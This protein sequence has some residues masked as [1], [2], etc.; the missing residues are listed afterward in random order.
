MAATLTKPTTPAEL[1]A[2][3]TLSI[4]DDYD[5]AQL[6]ELLAEPDV[7]SVLLI[8]PRCEA[9]HVLAGV[10]P[11]PLCV[12]WAQ[13]CARRATEY[14]AASAR[15]ADLARDAATYATYAADASV[16]ATYAD[17]ASVYAA[18][19][20]VSA[21]SAAN[22]HYAAASAAASAANA[23]CAANAID[24][25]RDARDARDAEYQIAIRHA[26]QLLGW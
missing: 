2:I 20:A 17:D 13:A 12:E 15:A 11:T 3:C 10:L 19:A 18:A 24:G 4:C 6:A 9:I 16:C 25:P 22:A 1:R 5:D 7:L 8:L 26:V 23:A 21:T 14:A